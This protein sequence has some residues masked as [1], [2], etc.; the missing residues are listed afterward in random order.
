MEKWI[1]VSLV[2]GGVAAAAGGGYWA[3]RTFFAPPALTL[4]LPTGPTTTGST[5]RL[6]I[7]T[8]TLP[9][10]VVGSSV[11]YAWTAANPSGALVWS[12]S[13]L[14]PGIAMHTNGVMAG[15]PTK[16]GKYLMRVKVTDGAGASATRST[17]LWV[18]KASGSA[19]GS[20]GSA[21][22]A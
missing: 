11:S 2:G 15:T 17:Y 6:A 3:Y 7:P 10:L 21:P 4:P 9:V 12:A 19:A 1:E 16:T 13:G 20:G 18:Q 14:P 8:Q 5:K 22:V